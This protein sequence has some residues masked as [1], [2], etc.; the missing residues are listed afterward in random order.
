MTP[1]IEEF[2]AT[3]IA[4]RHITAKHGVDLDEALEAAESTKKHFR[5][6]SPVP[7][8]NRYVIPGKTEGGTR[9]WVVFADEGDRRGRIITAREVCG[10]KEHARHRRH[11]GD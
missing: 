2:W 9:L 7:G 11:R 10:R 3:A 4:Q 1:I 5:T 8:E 6:Q